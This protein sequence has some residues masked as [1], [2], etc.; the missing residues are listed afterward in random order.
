MN[1]VYEFSKKI[2]RAAITARPGDQ[3]VL[4]IASTSVFECAE[5]SMKQLS[6]A[7]LRIQELEAEQIE[8]AL[9]NSEGSTTEEMLR[10]QIL[11]ITNELDNTKAELNDFKR[12]LARKEKELNASL[13]RERQN[14]P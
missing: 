2:L 9:G 5:A 8:V 7:E 11:N 10:A 14:A 3:N 1:Q 12:C 4:T 6:N 13:D